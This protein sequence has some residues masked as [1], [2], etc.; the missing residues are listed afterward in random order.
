MEHA[1]APH[2]TGRALL[3]F[4]NAA[5][6][7]LCP[8]QTPKRTFPDSLRSSLL[9]SPYS[10]PPPL[11]ASS[12]AV[13]GRVK[14]GY[15][16]LRLDG[17]LGSRLAKRETAARHAYRDFDGL[18]CPNTFEKGKPVARRGRKAYGPLKEVAG[19]PNRQEWEPS[20]ALAS[21]L[22]ELPLLAQT[23]QN[24]DLANLKPHLEEALE[25]L[26]LLEQ[27]RGLSDR[28]K[29]RGGALRM[30]LTSIEQVK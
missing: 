9:L 14:W 6:P 3:S 2:Y 21:A 19:L 27:K 23:P 29:M 10:G 30:L 4:R 18:Q 20:R 16:E 13:L 15:A 5:R 24:E 11:L 17:V 8:A 22:Q 26:E 7:T 25:T 28:E 12:L 1:P